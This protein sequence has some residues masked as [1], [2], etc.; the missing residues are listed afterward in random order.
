VFRH[1]I[2]YEQHVRN[3]GGDPWDQRNSLDVGAHCPCHELHHSAASRISARLLPERFWA[4]A[5]ELLGRD[6][7]KA[8]VRRY[9]AP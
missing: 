2:V 6:R 3:Q 9:Y 4:F 7:A 1:H 5:D 8:Y